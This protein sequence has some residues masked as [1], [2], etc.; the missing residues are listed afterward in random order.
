MA[1]STLIR[2]LIVVL[3]SL[4][5]DENGLHAPNKRVPPIAKKVNE[6]LASMP[7]SSRGDL[8]DENEVLFL[9]DGM[10]SNISSIGG[11]Q[12]LEEDEVD[13]YDGYKAQF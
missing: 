3:N 11:G 1:V 12:N 4:D 10:A 8:G 9:E 7:S 5:G 6:G 13:D 2:D